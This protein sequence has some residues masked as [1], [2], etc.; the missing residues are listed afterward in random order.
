MYST[1]CDP[2]IM[3]TILPDGFPADKLSKPEYE[4]MSEIDVYVTMRDG[5]KIA[6]DIHRPDAPGQFPVLFM[7]TG[8][9]KALSFLPNVPTI[10]CV[11][12]NDIEWFVKRGYIVAIQ[13]QRGTG[14][15]VDGEWDYIG[16]ETQYDLYDCIEW[17]GVQ[18]WS[19]G[20]VGMIGESLLAHVQWFAAALQPPH[21]T[22]IIPYDGG[23]DL[24]RDIAYHGGNLSVGFP[25][26]WHLVEIRAN[27]SLGMHWK[28]PNNLGSWDMPRAMI[29][30]P[31]FDDFWKVRR[32]DFSKI[33]CSLYSIGFW[34]KTGLHLRG[35][36]RG[37][38]EIN[39]PK[40]MLLCH[41]EFEGDEMAIYNS[42]EMRMLILR[43][44]DHWL[45]GNDTGVMD[46]PP[47][48]LFVHGLE[49]YRIEQEWPLKRADYKSFYLSGD[50]TGVVDSLNDGK[51]VYEEQPTADD[52]SVTYS[53]PQPDWSHFSGIGAAVVEHGKVYSYK[54]VLTFTTDPME[55]DMEVCGHARLILYASTDQEFPD[56][57]DTKFYI[58][59][60]DQL[61]D[62]TQLKNYPLESIL[63]AHGRLRASHSFEHDKELERPWRP[64]YTHEN[65]QELENNK[66]YEYDIEILPFANI[67]K[68]GHRLR[69]ELACH[70]TNM[71][72][73]GGH[74]YGLNIGKDTIYFDKEHKSRLI[75][76]IT[77]K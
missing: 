54:K 29:D 45:K 34:H 68:K 28:H 7:S 76:P 38:E 24:Y 46:E 13:D 72:D 43:W 14:K 73:F 1:I 44:I 40:K 57:V 50:T 2:E 36:T 69:M 9:M 55:E 18:P 75:L 6:M 4:M 32:P 16:Q 64:Y 53:Y 70:D 51:L 10:H 67:F 37:Y 22:T 59:I 31:T 12:T 11:E 47:V 74:H 15:S 19:T 62:D 71:F 33:T 61:P 52:A 20:K 8:Y 42:P 63:L 25:S 49:E 77:K 66:I 21:L 48:T 17:L 30:H 56:Y 5:A 58:K 23:A 26:A 3:K 27:Y 41:G 65:P 39:A 35:N 60:W